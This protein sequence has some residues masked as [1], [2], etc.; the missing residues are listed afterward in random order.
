MDEICPVCGNGKQVLKLAKT[1]Q[2]LAILGISGLVMCTGIIFNAAAVLSGIIALRKIKK[3]NGFYLGKNKAITGI[4][5]GSFL[6]VLTIL[7]ACSFR[8]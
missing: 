5:L 4:V 2:V 3:S 7:L 1:S 6:W 8:L